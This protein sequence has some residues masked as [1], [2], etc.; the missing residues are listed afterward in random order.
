[1]TN[2]RFSG[3]V[4]VIT[5]AGVGIGREI[6]RH[7]VHEGAFV[8]LNDLDE[9]L[10]HATAAELNAEGVS[11][12]A[13]GAGGDVSDV[14]TVRG[15]VALAVN[16]WGRLDMA[17]ANAGLTMW[18]SFFEL[19]PEAFDRVTS[20][21]LRG[22]FFLAQAAASQMRAQGGGSILLMSSVTGHQAVQYLSAYGMTKAAL[23]MLARNLVVELSP[24]GI[25]VNCVAPGATLTPRNLAD[26]PN[27]AR[28]WGSVTPNGRVAEPADIA[29]AALFLL[30]PASRHITG[31]T[32]VVDGGW[33][34]T[35][36]TPALT[37]VETETDE[38]S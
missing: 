16:K 7:L 13:L 33:T 12:Y 28:S 26:D 10:A 8:V 20:V 6:A 19:T 2:T 27:Y 29:N 24:Y 11:G 37:F 17:I 30:A 15:L 25:N 4:A 36:P 3:Q 38:N 1:M 23:E 14:A 32:L 18:Q 9:A 34:A 22:S 5:G 31:Q 35:S 21:N